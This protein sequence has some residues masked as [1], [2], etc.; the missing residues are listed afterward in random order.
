MA[1]LGEEDDG[2]VVMLLNSIDSE[3]ERDSQ[4]GSRMDS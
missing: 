1:P 2:G 4:D 3:G